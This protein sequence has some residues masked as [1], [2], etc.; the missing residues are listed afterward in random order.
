M[1]LTRKHS[2]F[3][4]KKERDIQRTK[5]AVV[6]FCYSFARQFFTKLII[7]EVKITTGTLQ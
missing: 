7:R 2:T 5:C 6:I 4:N 3:R 1:A